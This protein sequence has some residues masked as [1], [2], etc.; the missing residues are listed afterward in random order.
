MAAATRTSSGG[1]G[2][3]WLVG[4]VFVVLVI[5]VILPMAAMPAMVT[6]TNNAA[7]QAKPPAA[8][9]DE[10]LDAALNAALNAARA[11]AEAAT[12][13]AK[14]DA[15]EGV[16]KLLDELAARR[17]WDLFT[18][19]ELAEMATAKMLVIDIPGEG[20]TEVNIAH[21]AKHGADAVEIVQTGGWRPGNCNGGRKQYDFKLADDGRYWLRIKWDG[22]VITCF[23]ATWSYILWSF[24]Q[25]GCA[26]PRPPFGHDGMSSPAY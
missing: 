11:A 21:V 22:D 24:K 20:A 14:H 7:E 15:L 13:T 1:S 19:A 17:G 12:G 16:G 3:G 26:L 5:V 10:E 23:R 18:N 6:E 9:T 8:M 4:I 25:D 2:L